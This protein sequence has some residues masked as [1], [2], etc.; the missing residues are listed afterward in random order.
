MTRDQIAALVSRYPELIGG[1]EEFKSSGWYPSAGELYKF[2]YQPNIDSVDKFYGYVFGGIGFEHFDYG[3]LPEE[4]EVKDYG[5]KRPEIVGK[6]LKFFNEAFNRQISKYNS[7]LLN[8]IPDHFDEWIQ[9]MTERYDFGGATMHKTINRYFLFSTSFSIR[10]AHRSIMLR[11]KFLK[12]Q[13]SFPN[14][15][16]E[17]G[18]GH[19]KTLHDILKIFPV[20]TAYYID[21][22]LNLIIAARYLGQFYP[23][24]IHLVWSKDDFL[25]NGKINIVAPWHIE[26]IDTSIDL[27]VNYLSF[28]HM[29]MDAL[30]YY[31]EGI[32]EKNVKVIYHEN[33]DRPREGFDVG[34]GDYPFRRSFHVLDSKP[35]FSA[36]GHKGRNLGLIVS[37][38][39][40]RKQAV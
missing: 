17:I 20:K 16:L 34:L 28:Q 35:L 31:G 38:L 26:K 11:E 7:L 40:V 25:I 30:K 6:R 13:I 1:A 22:P 19:G 15:V 39:L 18:G 9:F 27:L 36:H 14:N 37:E 2:D 33:R 24:K 3:L 5:L 23:E 4:F 21:L 29:S 8:E 32:I 10:V 12:N